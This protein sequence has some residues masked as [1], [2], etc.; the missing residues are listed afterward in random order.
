MHFKFTCPASVDSRGVCIL[1]IPL[2]DAEAA[3]LS[4]DSWVSVDLKK[5][6]GEGSE[7]TCPHCGRPLH[8][9]DTYGA[10]ATT[11]GRILAKVYVLRRQ[12]LRD[13][14]RIRIPTK[15]RRQLGIAAGPNIEVGWEKAVPPPEVVAV[16]ERRLASVKRGMD[17]RVDAKKCTTCTRTL[18]HGDRF[19]DRCGAEVVWI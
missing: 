16:Y 3:Q 8:V 12:G 15:V 11:S 9:G 7:F 13:C 4:D 18:R 10:R 5:I 2:S 1:A 6:D 17:S 19:C 14:Y